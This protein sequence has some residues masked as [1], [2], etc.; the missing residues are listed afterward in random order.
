MSRVC[1]ATTASAAAT[2]A[3]GACLGRVLKPGSVLALDGDLG[4]GKTQFTQGVAAGMGIADP[5]TSPTFSVMVAYPH[6]SVPL[7]HFDL[8][9]LEDSAELEDIA[10]YD[11][12]EADGVACIEWAAK[13]PDALPD[14]RLEIYLV[15]CSAVEG[16]DAEG[17]VPEGPDAEGSVVEGPAFESA[18][19][20]SQAPESAD[21][22]GAASEGPDTESPA[23]EGTAPEGADAGT[24]QARREVWAEAYGPQAQALLQA[25][26]A[27][28]K[29]CSADW[30]RA[31]QGTYASEQ[32]SNEGKTHA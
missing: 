19:T 18:D 23:P 10:F 15:V 12:V 1:V 29:A 17:A 28:W 6:A 4:A 32:V 11:Y 25:W 22:K 21:A 20:E 31:S 16:A 7:Y 14:D 30:V 26:R 2:Q 9:R 8:Y 13:F 27:E 5:V 3:L 24:E